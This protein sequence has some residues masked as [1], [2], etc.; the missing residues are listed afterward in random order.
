MDLLKRTEYT[1]RN[2]ITEEDLPRARLTLLAFF[3]ALQV[4]ITINIIDR[5]IGVS[6]Q[7]LAPKF[8]VLTK[9]SVNSTGTYRK[10]DDIIV[11]AT[12]VF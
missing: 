5:N 11:D 10:T 2:N 1:E 8:K 4:V 6:S 7:R 3:S 9:E 12:P